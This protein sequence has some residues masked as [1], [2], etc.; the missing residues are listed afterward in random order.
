MCSTLSR[1]YT[2]TYTHLRYNLLQ[3]DIMRHSQYDRVLSSRS[4]DFH[5]AANVALREINCITTSLP[6]NIVS[7][8]GVSLNAR[9][10]SISRRLFSITDLL[11]HNRHFPRRS[12]T[13]S[14]HLYT[15]RSFFFG[16]RN[17][18][19]IFTRIGVGSF[20][21]QSV[22]ICR[23]KVE[24]CSFRIVNSCETSV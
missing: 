23:T 18:C 17:R 21:S 24:C 9:C 19:F 8:R 1:S 2:Y 6:L 20:W 7:Y 14:K 5:I 3:Y 16:S 11:I 15:L 22:V 12:S 10:V 4:T 13:R